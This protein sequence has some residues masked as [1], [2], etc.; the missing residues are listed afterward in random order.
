[1]FKYC[2][3]FLYNLRLSQFIYRYPKQ[4]SLLEIIEECR[5]DWQNAL[6]EFNFGQRDITDYLIYKINAAER[7]YMALLNQARAQK[8]TAWPD[9]PANPTVLAFSSEENSVQDQ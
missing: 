1:L 6:Q 4:M 9:E 3:V 7:R 8:L 2:R 5:L